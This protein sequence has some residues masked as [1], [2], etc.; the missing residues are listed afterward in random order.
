[1]PWAGPGRAERIVIIIITHTHTHTHTHIYIFIGGAHHLA[2]GAP[3]TRG[4]AGQPPHHDGARGRPKPKPKPKPNP[5]PNP[6]PKPKP[7]PKPTPTPTPTP[8][9]KPKPKP[10]PTPKQERGAD[11][12]RFLFL[13]PDFIID[14]KGRAFLVEMNTNGFM[15]GDDV[16]Y[17]M[18]KVSNSVSE[19]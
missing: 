5:K 16:L 8:K 19:Y 13:S 15:P 10:N 11:Y 9:P 14:Q 2:R 7:K 1:M 12:R 18:Q 17:K 3:L 4:A 6:K